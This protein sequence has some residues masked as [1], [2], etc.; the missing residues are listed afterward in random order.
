MIPKG[1]SWPVDSDGAARGAWIFSGISGASPDSSPLFGKDK[2][3]TFETVFSGMMQE[4]HKE[5]KGAILPAA[6]KMKRWRTRLLQEFGLSHG[7]RTHYQWSRTGTTGRVAR[8]P[9]K[10]GWQGDL[11]IDGGFSKAYQKVTRCRLY[12]DLQLLRADLKCT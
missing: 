9:V 12:S 6:W 11:I 10:C 4:A 8:V 3:A 2:M 5:T 7:G 1:H